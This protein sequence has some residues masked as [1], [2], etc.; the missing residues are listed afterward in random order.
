MRLSYERK[1][2]KR[3]LYLKKELN[4]IIDNYITEIVLRDKELDVEHF[5]ESLVYHI[6]DNLDALKH[7][8]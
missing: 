6:D 1:K 5:K 8:R 2:I 3:L 7:N 4:D